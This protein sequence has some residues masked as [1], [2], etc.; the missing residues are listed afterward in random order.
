MQKN[1]LKTLVGIYRYISSSVVNLS[2]LNVEKVEIN[3]KEHNFLK[4]NL[5]KQWKERSNKTIWILQPNN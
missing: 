1:L 3:V 5:K 4:S 2:E